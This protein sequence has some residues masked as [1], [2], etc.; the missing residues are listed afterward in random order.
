[1]TSGLPLVDLALVALSAF[2]TLVAAWL[3]LTILLNAEQKSF[4]VWLGGI[5]MLAAAVFFIYHA[6]LLDTD[7]NR[8]AGTIGAWWNA[9]WAPVIVLPFGWYIAMLWFAGFWHTPDSRLRRRHRIVLWLAGM[10]CVAVIV[11]FLASGQPFVLFATGRSDNRYAIAFT[12]PF[13]VATYLAFILLCT[14]A[15]IDA[16]RLLRDSGHVIA[17][18]ARRRARPWLVA[19]SALQ[20]V[21]CCVVAVAALMLAAEVG[22]ALTAAEL[23]GPLA[24]ADFAS[25]VLIAASFVLVGEAVVTYEIF[26][27]KILPR[28]GLR[29]HW[30]N[31][32]ALGAAA[33]I[34]SAAAIR[35]AI[36]PFWILV[37][38]TLV[39]ATFYALL[40]WRSYRGRERYLA[41]LRPFVGSQRLYEGMI[42]AIGQRERE[43][44]SA[45]PFHALCRDVLGARLA[46]L[47]PLGVAPHAAAIGPDEAPAGA[48]LAYPEGTATFGGP[49]PAAHTLQRS[50][51]C[52][53]VSPPE[54]GGAMWMIPLWNDRGL[55]GVLLLGEKLDGLYTQEELEIA[56]SSGERLID[57]LAGTEMARRLVA[58]E[59]QRMAESQVADA[60][61][62]RVL[63]D[64]ALPAIHAAMLAL[65]ADSSRDVNARTLETLADLHHMLSD[66]LRELPVPL[67]PNLAR[68]GLIGTLRGLVAG[69]LRDTFDDVTWEVEAGAE[70]AFNALTPLAAEVLYYAAREA[71]RNA[72]RY[73]RGRGPLRVRIRVLCTP[74]PELAIEDNGPGLDP[75]RGSDGGSGQ[76]LMLHGTMLAVVGWTLA[77]ENI[78]GA[79]R[80]VEGARVTMRLVQML[81][82]D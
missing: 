49:L 27:G 21:V 48:A 50:D 64:D 81:N 67:A 60:R 3:G 40:N 17:D 20:V 12:A 59:R 22:G 72:G 44:A 26:T 75:A 77:L 37:G 19:T 16:L 34:G 24:W 7:T 62:R 54:H 10:L 58:L 41:H 71:L 29:R 9:G 38:T 36:P 55:A 61:T 2:C 30:H 33:G 14:L 63:H 42:D 4:G 13:A 66:L 43:R 80:G 45:A 46:Y 70:E 31:T 39:A 11:Q 47:V 65:Q 53:P 32:L 1:M 68:L 57:L 15:A 25:L 76:G 82:I 79:D 6:A 8:L 78:T 28:Q 51:L 5:G 23:L 56:R 73:A 52:V 35:F 69:E 18:T 74:T